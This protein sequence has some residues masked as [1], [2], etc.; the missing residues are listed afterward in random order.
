MIHFVKENVYVII[1]DVDYLNVFY[2]KQSAIKDANL[3][4][5]LKNLIKMMNELCKYVKFKYDNKFGLFNACP[6]FIGTEMHGSGVMLNKMSKDAINEWIESKGFKWKYIQGKA[7]LMENKATI[8]KT[9]S[10]ILCN[11]LF[12]MRDILE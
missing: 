6:R 10:E 11:L 8:G 7:E 4:K 3:G 1:N 12:Y 5:E 9:E 2:S